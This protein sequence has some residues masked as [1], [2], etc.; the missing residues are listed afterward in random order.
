MS[1][2]LDS[3]SSIIKNVG[4]RHVRLYDE[5]DRPVRADEISEGVI[6]IDTTH[7]RTHQGISFFLNRFAN[8]AN[9]GT[10]EVLIQVPVNEGAHFRVVVQAASLSELQIFEGTTFSAA[11]TTLTPRN[12]RRSSSNSSVLIIT[13]TPT[14]TDDG[15]ELLKVVIPAGSG[16]GFLEEIDLD[17]NTVYLLRATNRG[18][19]AAD[20]NFLLRWYEPGLF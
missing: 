3:L 14:I 12:R 10:I 1:H 7:R 15:T 11:G 19:G 16:A 17:Q 4:V 5:G 18:G 9:N 2:L 6:T 8:I 20:L 13:H